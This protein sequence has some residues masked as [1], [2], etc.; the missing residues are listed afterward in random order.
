MDVIPPLTGGVT[1]ISEAMMIA[2]SV[3]EPAAGE[4]PWNAATPYVLQDRVYRPN[5]RIYERLTNGTSPAAPENDTTNWRD[6]GPS[7][8]WAPFDLIRNTGATAPSPLSYTIKPGRR[9]DAIGL[10]GIVADSFTVS[11]TKDGEEVYSRTES[12]SR[13]IVLSWRDYFFKPFSF[14]SV[15][16]LWDL[17]S[18]TNVE[19]TVTFYRATG[20]VTIGSIHIGTAVDM[21]ETEIDP[22]DDAQNYSTFSRDL[23][24]TAS[25]FIP[26]RVIPLISVRSNADPER[27]PEIRAVREQLRATPAFWAGLRDSSHPYF[28]SMV[29]VGVWKTLRIT[30]GDPWAVVEANLEEA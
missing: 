30:N 1:T 17:P 8:R 13:R 14:R 21:G 12:L 10:A 25:T 29:L 16:A 9:V 18:S 22:Q 26:R 5:H 23:D 6:V 11:V 27:A 3:P 20:D 24:G 7:L 4:I 2:S 28:E 19:I 15:A